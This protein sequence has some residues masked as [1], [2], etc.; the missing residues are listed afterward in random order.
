MKGWMAL[1]GTVVVL[2]LLASAGVLHGDLCAK[3]IGCVGAND[4]GIRFHANGK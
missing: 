4:A 2:L 1:I 3:S